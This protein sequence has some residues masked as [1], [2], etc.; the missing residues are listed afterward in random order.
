MHRFSTGLFFLCFLCS[1]LGRAEAPSIALTFNP[2][3]VHDLDL[4]DSGGGAYQITTTGPD[5]YLHTNLI[6]KRFDAEEIRVLSFEYINPEVSG[7]QVFF[8]PSI[9][10]TG[11]LHASLPAAQT[12]TAFSLDMGQ[13]TKWKSNIP[14][15]RMDFGDGA[16]RTIQIR[17]L[18]LRTQTEE[19]KSAARD[20]PLQNR[21]DK[22]NRQIEMYLRKKYPCRICRVEVSRDKVTVKGELTDDY[23]AAYLCE[24]PVHESLITTDAVEPMPSIST[25]SF[26]HSLPAQRG[27]FTLEVDRLR[28]AEETGIRDRLFSRWVIAQRDPLAAGRFC[29][30][31]H[32][33][34]ADAR[35]ATDDPPEKNPKR[36][37]GIDAMNDPDVLEMDCGVVNVVLNTLFA[38]GDEADAIGYELNGRTW[39]FNRA[40]VEHLDRT[41]QQA[42]IVLFKSPPDTMSGKDTEAYQAALDFLS[43]RYSRPDKKFGWIDHWV[44]GSETDR[45]DDVHGPWLCMDRYHKLMRIACLTAWKY[46]PHA[47]VLIAFPCDKNSEPQE[48]RDLYTKELLDILLDY[49]QTEGNFEW[50]P[51]HCSCP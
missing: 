48:K 40:A 28:G 14:F 44:I 32:A 18:Q 34:W 9:T 22:E 11:S 30:L 45:A 26:I 16:G 5:P 42:G 24:V 38:S 4:T 50:M 27:M 49:E 46:N 23:P 25:F 7:F 12:W 31:S 1:A 2:Q 17:H 8:A 36:I 10:E 35:P 29:L 3:T 39:C 47:K 37:K 19:E 41:L 43:A 51:I 21:R 6:G 15:I 33:R 20:R 13:S